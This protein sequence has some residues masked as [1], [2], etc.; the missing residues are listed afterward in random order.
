MKNFALAYGIDPLVPYRASAVLEDVISSFIDANDS[1]A[2]AVPMT[3]ELDV[4]EDQL[5]VD[6]SSGGVEFNPLAPLEGSD[7]DSE[8]AQMREESLKLISGL[9]DEA[10]YE[11][12]DDLNVLHLKFG[13]SSLPTGSM[14][15]SS[16]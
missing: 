3:V 15:R 2:G 16:G 12:C 5:K 8:D 6:V 7:A 14:D 4:A 9:S 10:V 1:D 13:L 11:R